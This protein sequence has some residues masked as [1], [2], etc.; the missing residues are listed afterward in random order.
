VSEKTAVLRAR[1]SPKFKAQVMDFLK[2][3]YPEEDEAWI[4]RNAVKEFMLRQGGG[5]L[6]EEAVPYKI[7]GGGSPFSSVDGK[8]LHMAAEVIA[9]AK[10]DVAAGVASPKPPTTLKSK[11]ASSATAAAAGPKQA[12]ALKSKPK[13]NPHPAHPQ[14]SAKRPT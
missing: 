14:K 13:A 2:T 8:I 7:A 9:A 6:R 4:V 1:C 12:P 10:A 11:P 3:H 5:E